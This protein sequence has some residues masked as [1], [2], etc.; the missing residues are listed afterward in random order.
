MDGSGFDR[1][2]RRHFGQL[3]A[4]LVAALTGSTA[5]PD[6]RARKKRR[7][8]KRKPPKICRSLREECGSDA[9]EQCCGGLA[10]DDNTCV[11]DPVCLQ[12]DGGSCSDS[13]DCRLGLNCSDRAR[14]TCRQCSLPQQ[15][16]ETA[17]DCCNNASACATNSCFGPPDTFCCQVLGA[18]CTAP[19][20]CCPN[21]GNCG[22]NG[23][24]GTESVCCRGQGSPCQSS[25][26]CCD[27]LRCFGGM[28]Q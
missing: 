2:T 12:P 23:C 24:G 10:C 14:N 9:E 19:C 22:L 7:K 6:I 16:C 1:W 3:A 21:P 11:S 20:E 28:C 17:D 18:H 27:P 15:P 5:V 13:C 25:C 26:E 4:G 8:R